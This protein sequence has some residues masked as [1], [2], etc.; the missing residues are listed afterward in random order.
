VTFTIK[1][2]TSTAN[3]VTIVVDGLLKREWE[4]STLFKYCIYRY[5]TCKG[6]KWQ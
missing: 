1:I 3:T 5:N 6:K 4:Q 2:F